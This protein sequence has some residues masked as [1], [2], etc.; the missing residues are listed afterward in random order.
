MLVNC[1]K[2]QKKV[3]SVYGS[4]VYV[5]ERDGNL[6]LSGRLRSWD[7]I[8]GA[9]R[10]CVDRKR[11][12]HVIN[13]IRLLGQ[14]I[15]RTK[16]PHF[17]DHAL[18]G[19]HP[20]VLV[21]GGGISG[22]SIA[23]ELM[24]WKL[25][26]LLV[27]KEADVA[28]HSSS[29]NDGEVHPGVDLGRGTVKQR[30]V[31]A[32]NRMY[33]RVCNELNVPFWRRGQFVEMMHW[34]E[35]LPAAAYVWHR[36]HICGVDDTQIVSGRAVRKKEPNL[37]KRM[38]FAIYNPSAG[39]V[40][41]H[42][43][44]IA[45]AENAVQNGAQVSLNTAVLS[46]DVVKGEIKSVQTNRGTIYPKL[47]IN[48]AGTFAEEVAQ[49]AKD[50][51]YSIHPRRGT[52]AILDRKAGDLV[53]SIVSWKSV[54]RSKEHTKGGGIVHTADDNLLVGP[55][56]VETYE[57]ENFA[58]ELSSIVN[59]FKKQKIAMETLSEKDI[60]TYYTGV[61]AATFEEDFVIEPGRRTKN[62]IHCAGIQSPGL[63]TAPAV[64]M[65]VA[66]MAAEMLTSVMD[67]PVNHSFNPYRKRM[68]KI[69]E[70]SD[71]QKD[72]LIR[73]RPDYGVM[74]CRCEEITKGEIVDALHSPLPVYTIDGI[75]KRVRPGTGRCQGGFCMPLVAQ[76]ISEETGCPMERIKKGGGNSELFLGKTK[77]GDADEV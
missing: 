46:M 3:Q 48:A 2:L 45:Y 31:V 34:S 58:T 33:G 8:I 17:T 24:R 74:I 19:A 59:N 14:D 44:T 50:R 25:S 52:N 4:T 47:V 70:L 26:V 16:V 57:K 67:V 9:C 62:L 61:R 5:R 15:P 39:S 36:K 7:D 21:I 35:L 41:P 37:S 56:A 54:K 73:K 43:L 66:R 49:M 55:D 30:Y 40:C 60:I 12:Y 75:K 27:E 11:R 71:E 63:T 10:M 6:V 76:I 64:A 69:R 1:R 42:S 20:D 22:V 77:R 65:D 68:P 18:E 13:N 72:R 28:L 32:G 29:R 23:R 51:F 53:G 38:K